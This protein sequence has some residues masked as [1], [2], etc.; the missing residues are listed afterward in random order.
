MRIS[1]Y[2]TFEDFHKAREEEFY[3]NNPNHDSLVADSG[4]SSRRQR[5]FINEMNYYIEKAIKA[6]KKAEQK[7]LETE[8]QAEADMVKA[9]IM[10]KYQPEETDINKSL[11]NL[12]KGLLG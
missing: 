4:R 2:S 7:R 5:L 3:K 11:M 12:M 1:D 8:A 9:E 10:A 6:E